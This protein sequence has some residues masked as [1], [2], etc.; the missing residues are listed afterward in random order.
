MTSVIRTAAGC[1]MA[2]L[3]FWG[4]MKVCREPGVPLAFFKPNFVKI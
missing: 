2:A 1:R 4:L 3:T